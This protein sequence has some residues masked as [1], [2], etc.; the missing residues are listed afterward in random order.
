MN[1]TSVPQEAGPSEVSFHGATLDTVPS[2]HWPSGGLG[3]GTNLDHVSSERHRSSKISQGL[4]KVFVTRPS[5]QEPAENR[6]HLSSSGPSGESLRQAR[7][8]GCLGLPMARVAFN[9]CLAVIRGISF[10][11]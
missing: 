6:R 10:W 5:L 11:L 3:L 8:A 9:L 4:N 1:Q 2:A 7:W